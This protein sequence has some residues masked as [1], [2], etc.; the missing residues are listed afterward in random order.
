M[1]RTTKYQET[2]AHLYEQS[3]NRDQAVQIYRRLASHRTDDPHA[4]YKL[5]TYAQQQ[6][7]LARAVAYYRRA[8]RLNPDHTGFQ[9]ALELALQQSAKYK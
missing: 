9:K 6:G 7:H 5:G 2:L 3:G 4:F 1:P 8:L